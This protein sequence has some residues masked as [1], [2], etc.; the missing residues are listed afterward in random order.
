MKVNNRQWHAWC[1]YF[2]RQGTK[3]FSQVHFGTMTDV[4]FQHIILAQF[5][6]MIPCAKGL[7]QGFLNQRC[8]SNERDVLGWCSHVMWRDPSATLPRS[9]FPYW[10]KAVCWLALT[11]SVPLCIYLLLP[12]VLYALLLRAAAASMQNESQH[13][14]A[15]NLLLG[16]GFCFV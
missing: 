12:H 8:C 14:H 3:E 9:I 1:M 10:L 15:L 7:A 11:W 2:K 5:F 4:D 13:L 6:F 16:Y